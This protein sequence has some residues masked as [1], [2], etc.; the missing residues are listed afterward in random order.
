MTIVTM[1]TVVMVMVMSPLPFGSSGESLPSYS[2]YN[3]SASR[4]VLSTPARMLTRPSPVCGP[5]A[6]REFTTS[7]PVAS[8][9]EHSETKIEDQCHHQVA[10]LTN[11]TVYAPHGVNEAALERVMAAFIPSVN[12][13][14]DD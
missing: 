11:T 4:I 14:F 8:S 6:F 7:S 3:M 9:E 10:P 13:V 2:D 1:V 5:I 12:Y